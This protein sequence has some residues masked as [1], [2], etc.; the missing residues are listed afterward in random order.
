[1]IQEFA[2][3]LRALRGYSDNTINAYTSDVRE[4]AR[5]IQQNHVNERWSTISR[6]I[7]DEYVTYL[8]NE[9]LAA[10]STNRKLSS[11][12]ALYNYMM[13]ENLLDENPVKYES[14]R[15]QPKTIPATIPVAAI[16]KAYEHARGVQKTML[17]LLAST[18]MRLQE[19]LD[20]HWE[21]INFS[22]CEILINGKGSKQRIV[23]SC[24]EV[25]SDLKHT[26]ETL[27][28]HGKIFHQ[29]QRV[30]RQII[31]DLIR[32]YTRAT[33]I[34]PHVIRHTFA[35]ELAKQGENIATIAKILGHERIETSQK[36]INMVEI[37]RP[38]GGLLFTTTYKS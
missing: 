24:Q 13:R 32:P 21:D 14:R 4:F 34:S 1:M 11:I 29:G 31:W 36:Y 3:Y 26:A 38:N 18:G 33:K 5:W 12:A 35:T 17:G 9:G 20:L 22:T 30:T 6:H 28:V 10:S 23:V 37:P 15:K 2:T 16:Q 25:L 8:Y 7:I 19:M 27:P